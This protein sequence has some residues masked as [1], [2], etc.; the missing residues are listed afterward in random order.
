[1][2]SVSCSCAVSSFRS[3]EYGAPSF[4][5]GSHVRLTTG[6]LQSGQGYFLNLKNKRPP[7]FAVSAVVDDKSV[8]SCNP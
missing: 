2:V 7:R 4:C 1:M 8:V 3:V 6:A 5:A